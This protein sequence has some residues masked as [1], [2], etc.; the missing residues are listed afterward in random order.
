MTQYSILILKH[1]TTSLAAVLLACNIA[2]PQDENL[3]EQSPA[4][5]QSDDT[6]T[7]VDSA[8][9]SWND[10]P[11]VQDSAD[12]TI[13]IK[14]KNPDEGERVEV[15]YGTEEG[16]GDLAAMIF[17]TVKEENQYFL[18][19]ENLKLH[20]GQSGLVI[21]YFKAEKAYLLQH[22]R[23]FTLKL[24]DESLTE[25]KYLSKKEQQQQ[26]IILTND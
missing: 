9:V 24:K 7:Q 12:I 18:V 4:L 3:Y 2:F 6:N 13:T 21:V 22:E 25:V 16:K 19:Y 20:V 15:Y 10:S 1:L 5:P 11:A 8:S 17:L 14:I 26:K 23:Y